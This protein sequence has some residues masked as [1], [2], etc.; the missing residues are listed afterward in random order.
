VLTRSV[1]T[2]AAGSVVFVDNQEFFLG[3][4]VQFLNSK[5]SSKMDFI[6]F[7]KKGDS[8]FKESFSGKI[9]LIKEDTCITYTLDIENW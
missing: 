6:Y 5:K 1:S 8:L 3:H 4:C 9:F 2:A 7:A